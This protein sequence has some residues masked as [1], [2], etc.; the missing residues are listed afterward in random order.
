MEVAVATDTVGATAADMEAIGVDPHRAAVLRDETSATREEMM[1]FRVE[2]PETRG[3]EVVRRVLTADA[4]AAE[5]ALTSGMA[6]AADDPVLP[7]VGHHRL[8]P[9]PVNLHF[10][11]IPL[12]LNCFDKKQQKLVF[13]D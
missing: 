3:P 4:A 8:I 5:A 9:T 1:T 2:D 11:H 6:A 10:P 13:L 7:R 12:R